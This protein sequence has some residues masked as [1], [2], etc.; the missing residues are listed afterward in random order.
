MAFE[1]VG[2]LTEEGN[3]YNRLISDREGEDGGESWADLV[4]LMA[5]VF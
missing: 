1:I 2:L 3:E 5:T 4:C